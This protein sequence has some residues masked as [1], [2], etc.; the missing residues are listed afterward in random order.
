MTDYF[1]TRAARYDRDCGRGLWRLVKAHEYHN[2][3]RLLKPQPGQR[4][5]DLGCGTGYY[6]ERLEAQFG[7]QATGVDRSP[8]MLAVARRKDIVCV[9]ARAEELPLSLGRFDRVLATGLFEFV[10]EP[11]PVFERCRQLLETCG[12][13]VILVPRGALV[14]WAYERI[15]RWWDCETHWREPDQYVQCAARVG[16]RLEAK[17]HIFPLATGLAFTF[18]SR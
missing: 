4:V 17:V 9:Q 3:I 7:V 8:A 5:L 6:C 18:E 12:R 13:L 16:L 15:H 10:A 1:D 2:V 14:G 11:M